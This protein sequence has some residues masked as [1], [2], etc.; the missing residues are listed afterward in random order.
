MYVRWQTYQGKRRGDCLRA[1]L[2]ESL[3]V[4]GKP[5]QKH[6]AVLGSIALDS[7]GA[8]EPRFWSEVTSK[9]KRLGDRIGPEDY[10]RIIASIAAKVGGPLFSSLD[11]VAGIAAAV[12]ALG[13]LAMAAFAVGGL[14]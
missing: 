2:V 4:D 11:V 9:L 5:R 6:I 12:M 14:H 13:P 10:E 1:V 8:P 3:C 7:V